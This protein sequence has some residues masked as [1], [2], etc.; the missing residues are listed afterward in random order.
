LLLVGLLALASCGGHSP[1]REQYEQAYKLYQQAHYGPA[2]QHID[3]LKAA[4][5]KNYKLQKDLLLLTR[6]ITL[7]EQTRNLAFCD[8]LIPL[9]QAEIDDLK[10]HFAYEKTA[11]DTEGHYTYRPWNP[12]LESGFSGIRTTLT[13]S[14]DLILTAIHQGPAPIHYTHLRLSLPTGEHAETQILPPDGGAHYTFTDGAGRHY[15]ILTF[16][17]G[18]DNGVIAFIYTYASAPITLTYAGGNPT[19]SRLLTPQETNALIQ[20]ADFAAQLREL[21]QLEARKAAAERQIRNISGTLPTG[22]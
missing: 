20:T 4:H 11:Y 9:L 18:R 7:K 2:R 14:N 13:E 8:S 5:P 10:P 1:A 17:K 6:Q 21:A 16:H 3:R 19:P 22:D 15:E 12:T